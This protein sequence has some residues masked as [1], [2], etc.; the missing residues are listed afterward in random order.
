[1]SEATT[2]S[3]MQASSSNFS[4]RFFSAVRSPTRSIRYRVRSCN[5]R[6]GR[7]GTKLARSIW[8]SHHRE[9][10][11]SGR[12]AEVRGDHGPVGVVLGDDEVLAAG[13]TAH[14]GD[15]GLQGVPTRGAGPQILEQDVHANAG[16][17]LKGEPGEQLG[18]LA[19]RRPEPI[20][21]SFEPRPRPGRRQSAPSTATAPEPPGL[22]AV[23]ASSASRSTVWVCPTTT[24]P[25]ST[26]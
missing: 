1:M 19:C 16:A 11:G 5:W 10:T 20:T 24:P 12:V 4:T 25:S 8:R 13:G 15:P 14:L 17:F 3:L 18:G 26:A 7:G 9:R 22:V 2:D 21:V 6:I 23:S